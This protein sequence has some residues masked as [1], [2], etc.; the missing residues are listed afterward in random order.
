MILACEYQAVS[1]FIIRTSVNILLIPDIKITDAI[2]F[3]QFLVITI[4]LQQP[5]YKFCMKYLFSH[6]I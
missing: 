2:H 5:T 6:I 3:L 4:E 1:V